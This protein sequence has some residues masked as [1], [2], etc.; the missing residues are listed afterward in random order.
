M[1]NGADINLVTKNMNTVF[2]SAAKFGNMELIR[3]LVDSG[4]DVNVQ[5]NDGAS[6]LMRACYY[7]YIDLVT[8]LLDMKPG[9]MLEMTNLRLETA[10]YIAAFRGHFEI[11][12]LMVS[13]YR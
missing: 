13:Y 8:Y 3:L 2:L 6:G 9:R 12:Q 5:Y 1:N 4:V 7:N 10:L 11:V